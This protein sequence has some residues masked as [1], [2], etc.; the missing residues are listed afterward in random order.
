MV[1]DDERGQRSA[2]RR[3]GLQDDPN[4]QRRM[5]VDTRLTTGALASWFPHQGNPSYVVEVMGT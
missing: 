1:S 3:G 5:T 4:R 2:G